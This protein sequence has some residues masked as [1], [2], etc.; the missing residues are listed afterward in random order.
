MSSIALVPT[1]PAARAAVLAFKGTT[2]TLVGADL[3]TRG[4]GAAGAGFLRGRPRPFVVECKLRKVISWSRTS[5]ARGPRAG[6]RSCAGARVL[7]G[8]GRPMEFM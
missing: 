1:T 8:M 3:R 2:G 6:A 5:T 7:P 4:F